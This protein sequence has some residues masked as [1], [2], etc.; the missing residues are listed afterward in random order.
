MQGGSAAC[1][2]SAR[3]H[4]E[5]NPL[6]LQIRQGCHVLQVLGNGLPS[7]RSEIRATAVKDT[8]LEEKD[9]EISRQ[10]NTELDHMINL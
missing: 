7:R 1:A 6:Q 4:H 9:S 5:A 3:S 8:W 10:Y 2:R